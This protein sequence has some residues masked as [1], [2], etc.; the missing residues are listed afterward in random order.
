MMTQMMIIDLD[1]VFQILSL[2]TFFF[3][4]KLGSLDFWLCICFELIIKYVMKAEATYV[5]PPIT[6]K[7]IISAAADLS[8][9]SLICL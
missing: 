6:L 9:C 7:P 8:C 1:V 3:K 2:S 4:E 5:W